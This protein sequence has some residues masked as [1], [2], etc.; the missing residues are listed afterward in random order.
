MS[1]VRREGVCPPCRRFGHSCQF[2][3]NTEWECILPLNFLLF[4]PSKKWYVSNR[5]VQCCMCHA[6][7]LLQAQLSKHQVITGQDSFAFLSTLNES[8]EGKGGPNQPSFYQKRS[9][10]LHGFDTFWLLL[11]LL[12]TLF[13]RADQTRLS[14]PLKSQIVNMLGNHGVTLSWVTNK[15]LSSSAL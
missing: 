8:F 1:H 11:R 9:I 14:W 5:T 12:T 15:N 10:G 13:V 4:A 2:N 7:H 6:Q 3:E